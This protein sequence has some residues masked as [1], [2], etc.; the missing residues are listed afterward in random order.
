MSLEY[1]QRLIDDAVPE[2][3]TVEYKLK[4]QVDTPKDKKEF[5]ADVSSFANASGGELIFGIEEDQGIPQGIAPISIADVDLEVRRLGSLI[6]DGIKPRISHRIDVFDA[7]AGKI[8]I[9]RV[10][11]SWNAPHRVIYDGHDKFY[12]RTSAGKYPMDVDQLRTAFTQSQGVTDRL[13]GFRIDR[14]IAIGKNAM[15]F[16]L[17]RG[18]KIVLHCIPVD[19]FSTTRAYD[20]LR[21][22]KDPRE[23]RPIADLSGW[24]TRITLEGIMSISGTPPSSYVHLYRN[25]II[26]GVDSR[27]LGAELEGTN[28]FSAR[29]VEQTVLKFLS[30]CLAIYR[31]LGVRPPIVVALTLTN[32]LGLENSRAGVEMEVYYPIDVETLILPEMVVDNLDEK[33]DKILKPSFD[34]TWNACGRPCSPNF[35]ENGNFR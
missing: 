3:I 8:L 23:F 20:V 9:V 18:G 1:I 34:L 16:R 14:V 25:G 15:P 27:R 33:A 5:L 7:R 22:E 12:A 13:R 11:R 6:R 19:A 24:Y 28:R 30:E 10:E 32:V 29:L 4:I 31:S 17:G 2:S 35:D 21:Y 26:E